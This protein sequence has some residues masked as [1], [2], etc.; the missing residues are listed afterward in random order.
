MAKDINIGGR[1]HSIATGNVV[2]GADE[3]LDDNLGK[4]Q[5][6]INTETYS[7]VE[8][9]N[10]ALDALNPDQQEALAVATKANA[11][12]A[13]LGYYVCDTD[14]AVSAKTIAATG[15]VLT[16]GGNI[17]VKMTNDNTVNN[18]TLNINSTGAKP[19]FYEG[20]R[21][22]STNTWVADDV[23]EIYYD[24]TNYQ[25]KTVNPTF[26][27]GEKIHNV[28]IDD[29][30]TA[31]SD[32]LVK[33]GGVYSKIETSE[34]RLQENIDSI[35]E[36]TL[37]ENREMV[38]SILEN[39]NPIEITGDVT[40]APDEED[41]TSV[42]VEG[43]DVLK[44]KDKA[45]NPLVY[46]GL[47]RKILRKNIVNDVNTL[48][49]SMMQD[50]NTIYI[51]QY[52][53]NLGGET[54]TIPANCVLKFDGGSISG[55]TIIGNDTVICS[56][57]TIIFKENLAF[58]G[59]W[60][61]EDY[62]AE[63][64][65]G[66]V[67]R[68]LDV[69][70]NVSFIKNTILDTPITIRNFAS[71]N[72]K[73]NISVTVSDDFD[74]DYLFIVDV[75]PIH[76]IADVTSGNS[77]YYKE[78]KIVFD[79]CGG[80]TID[81]ANKTCF[82]R[83]YSNDAI[84][85]NGLN[86]IRAAKH[87]EECAIVWSHFRLYA[88]DCY[89]AADRD[90][91]NNHP[92]YGIHFDSSDNKL[93]RIQ[94]IINTIGLHRC[95]GGSMFTEV[96][97]WGAP[98]I[99][100]Y[101]TG[102]CVFTDVYNDWGLTSFY[103]TIGT[104]FINGFHFIAPSESSE[105]YQDWTFYLIKTPTK[106]TN[107]NGVLH[108]NKEYGFSAYNFHMLGYGEETDY[109]NEN[110][111]P[112]YAVGIKAN[113]PFVNTEDANVFRKYNRERSETYNIRLTG[114][115][116]VKFADISEVQDYHE[117][118]KFTLSRK[119]GIGNICECEIRDGVLYCKTA[120]LDMVIIY[121]YGG[122]YYIRNTSS[123]NLFLMFNKGNYSITARPLTIDGTVYT[124]VSELIAALDDPNIHSASDL[125]TVTIRNAVNN[126]F[127]VG[128]ISSYVR[129]NYNVLWRT[130]DNKENVELINNN[131]SVFFHFLEN[132]GS[133][134]LYKTLIANS[135]YELSCRF[136]NTSLFAVFRTGTRAEFANRVDKII[137][138]GD[139][140][141]PSASLV[142][143]NKTSIIRDNRT[144][145]GPGTVNVEGMTTNNFFAFAGFIN[146]SGI[147]SAGTF[148]IYNGTPVWSTGT[149]W[150]DASG[151]V[152]TVTYPTTL[153]LPCPR[154]T[155]DDGTFTDSVEVKLSC[156]NPNASIYY[157]ID[158]TIPTSAST[159]YN[160][161]ITLYA[162]TTIKAIAI[163]TDYNDSVVVSKKYTKS[164]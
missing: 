123:S 145:S 76:H 162:T 109:Y 135:R 96:H 7:L 13:K 132:L 141:I 86:V 150:V 41:L 88:T 164:S 95:A 143:R 50:T 33:S 160:G 25:A 2:A 124:N 148:W 66:N 44:F 134:A 149:S 128:D 159:L 94:V 77:K 9:V 1:L 39:Y 72:F 45:Y 23:L 70:N 142:F 27:T 82:M 61:A 127:E 83:Q 62:L 75:D 36:E 103:V 117:S 163:L 119:I 28:G 35:K 73:S 136:D 126:S 42:N 137:I 91:K 78:P 147:P 125:E 89:F 155:P 156:A 60:I 65:G 67:E 102:L 158:G 161:A 4:K 81:L 55:G 49:Q 17:K 40:N 71:V 18:A 19:L 56:S 37:E 47:G 151:Q 122:Y 105:L 53:Y 121:K 64:F 154:F 12:E 116:I 87:A 43:T 100:F 97:V 15:Y 80:N 16:T 111:T 110:T 32:N 6:Q 57:P 144:I 69:F 51:I 84:Q 92:T 38:N 31:G 29:E 26:K 46:S 157:T 93:V 139:I 48:T 68:C 115:Q 106:N 104:I 22:S 54:V 133:E 118:I 20:A 21:A 107:I 153:Q 140:Y 11:N 79:G 112:Y 99:A 24:G 14:A 152:V 58:S 114:S 130:I 63:W 129:D 98:R 146:L 108:T 5:T 74:D 30:P 3:I 85:M 34:Q 138:E 101:V 59:T 131:G 8:S 10:N 52:D 90:N 120:I 113:S